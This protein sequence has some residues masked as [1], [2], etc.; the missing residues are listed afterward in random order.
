MISAMLVR[1]AALDQ[2]EGL[3]LDLQILK[4]ITW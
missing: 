4:W 2:A 1:G 3:H